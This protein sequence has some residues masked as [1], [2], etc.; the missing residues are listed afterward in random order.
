MR[1]AVIAEKRGDPS[2]RKVWTN[3]VGPIGHLGFAKWVARKYPSYVVYL[4]LI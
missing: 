2:S 3:F 4:E 1:Y